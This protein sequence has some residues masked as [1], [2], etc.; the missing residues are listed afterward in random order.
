MGRV[1]LRVAILGT[2]LA[3][4]A[5]ACSKTSPPAGSSSPA[6][7][8]PSVPTTKTILEPVTYGYYDGHV[9][10]MLSTDVNSKS[11]A[12]ARHINYS[13]ALAT[14]PAK[15]F[16]SLYMVAGTAAPN[17]PVVFGSEPGE[18]DYSPLWQEVTVQW[19]PGSKPVLLVRDDQIKALAGKGQ[20]TI[21]P[22]SVILNCPIVKAA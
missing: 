4:A 22:S 2:A 8:A 19:K 20:V 5:T 15:A 18:S 7:S 17:Q 6:A 16:P 10:A 12:E 13:A 21:T 9:D 11:Q 1:L 14:Q 3:V